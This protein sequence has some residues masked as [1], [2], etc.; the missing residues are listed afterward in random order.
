MLC[1]INHKKIE[2][3]WIHKFDD[4]VIRV[5]RQDDNIDYSLTFY[6]HTLGAAS[7]TIHSGVD[8]TVLSTQISKG[9]EINYTIEDGEWKKYLEDHKEADIAPRYNTTWLL[10]DITKADERIKAIL[11]Y[12][13]VISGENDTDTTELKILNSDILIFSNVDEVVSKPTVDAVSALSIKCFI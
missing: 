12:N 1:N 11:T 6:R 13:Q 10:P 4:G 2:I 3:R 9:D 7:H 8:W 5:V